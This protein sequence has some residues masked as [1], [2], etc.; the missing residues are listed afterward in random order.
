M[1]LGQFIAEE[2]VN[3]F[4]L[5]KPEKIRFFGHDCWLV[6]ETTRAFYNY[7]TDVLVCD[8]KDYK[9]VWEYCEGLLFYK[10]DSVYQV[11]VGKLLSLYKKNYRNGS[12]IKL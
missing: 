5:F 11:D 6:N 8:D 4:S 7:K 3:G 10:D 9:K 12:L 2:V 1:S